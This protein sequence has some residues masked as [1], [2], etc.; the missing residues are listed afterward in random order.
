[1]PT[2]L[3]GGGLAL[4]G[5]IFGANKAA[6]AA[7]ASSKMQMDMYRQN[8]ENLQPW[9]TTGGNALNQYGAAIGLNGP[10][11]QA[12]YYNQWQNDPYYKGIMEAGTNAI[13]NSAL[14][15]GRGYGGNVLND[16]N[17]YSMDLQKGAYDQ[18]LNQLFGV[19]EAGRGAGSAVAGVGTTAAANAGNF[20][21]NA[22]Y[23]QG[24]GIMGGANAL[25]NA[26][27]TDAT[28]QALGNFFMPSFNPV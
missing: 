25:T 26:L 8:K 3:I 7:K 16:L 22:G 6:D 15:R 2:S 11:A 20:N 10:G 12:D 19:S 13:Q 28:R 21:A 24:A 17:R 23:A 14:A 27:N 4:A 18:R 5:S 9:M 1:M